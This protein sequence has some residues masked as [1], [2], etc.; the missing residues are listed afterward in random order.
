MMKVEYD[1]YTKKN[2][3]RKYF[4]GGVTTGDIEKVYKET[5]APTAGS[6]LIRNF[7]KAT[8]IT[9]IS[10]MLLSDPVQANMAADANK[11]M[12]E[13]IIEMFEE[14]LGPE[15]AK[16]IAYDYVNTNPELRDKLLADAIAKALR[17]PDGTIDLVGMPEDFEDQEIPAP[18]INLGRFSS[19]E[20]DHNSFSQDAPK[21]ERDSLREDAMANGEIVDRQIIML[22]DGSKVTIDFLPYYYPPGGRVGS[23]VDENYIELYLSVFFDDIE[24]IS[25]DMQDPNSFLGSFLNKDLFSSKE[26][27]LAFLKEWI[28]T[29]MIYEITNVNRKKDQ[30][31]DNKFPDL[32]K[33]LDHYRVPYGNRSYQT[34]EAFEAYLAMLASSRDAKM[35]MAQLFLSEMQIRTPIHY[36]SKM[37]L[38]EIL[39]TLGYK[40]FVFAKEKEFSENTE[41]SIEKAYI[42]GEYF[43]DYEMLSEFMQLLKDSE[44]IQAAKD[45]HR[46]IFNKEAYNIDD[47]IFSFI[48]QYF[49]EQWPSK[50][51]YP[52][53]NDTINY[54]NL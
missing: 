9:L 19:L 42:K 51:L 28:R 4:A 48:K 18:G 24:N 52:F 27:K 40:K 5:G 38:R 12:I 49:D 34:A 22:P 16:E 13:D 25:I 6:A 47:Y 53:N 30:F 46:K 32:D 14:S 35:V 10:L 26:G 7:K 44:I 45:L 8:L 20:F 43:H 41:E 37:I 3:P 50:D 11:K 17:P 33:L 2:I 21:I 54:E 39:D 29:V 1:P 31:E 36:A 15:K 23:I